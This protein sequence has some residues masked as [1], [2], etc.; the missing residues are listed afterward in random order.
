[1]ITGHTK[2]YGI[3]AHPIAHVKTPEEMNNHFASLGYDGVL[4]PFHVQPENLATFIDT[5]RRIENFGGLIVTVP[6]KTAILELCDS[7]V[8]DAAA[9]GA[10]NTIRRDPDGSLVGA[11]LDGK[12]FV[13]GLEASAIDVRGMK[14]CL[15]GA[16]G[17]ASA[18]AFA[19]A[20]A[21][22]N[23]LRIVNRSA[24]KAEDLARRVA[25]HYPNVKASAGA[26]ETASQDLVVNATSLGLRD[27]DPLPLE[28]TAFHSG[29]IVA[30]AI[31]E[32]EVTPILATAR[33]KGALIHFG[34]PM[35]RQQ[36]RLMAEHMGVTPA[37]A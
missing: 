32:P 11:M 15:L 7:V 24:G 35:L 6:H 19:L 16:G 12:G 4:V 8:G 25:E 36:I 31:M 10:V 27:G 28:D 29:Q 1:M 26:P 37:K 20:E 23:S 2:L 21:G 34:R 13:R 33:E 3:V 18:I 22:V 5:L 17:A 9:I 30:E 14:S